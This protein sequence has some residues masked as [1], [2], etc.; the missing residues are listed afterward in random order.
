[1]IAQVVLGNRLRF[2]VVSL[3]ILPPPPDNL[4]RFLQSAVC[5]LRTGVAFQAT[6]VSK[7]AK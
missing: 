4:S 1:M 6:S 5:N 3:A 2:F 7:K